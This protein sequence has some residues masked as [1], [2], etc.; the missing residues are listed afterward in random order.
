MTSTTNHF[1]G[2][3][4]RPRVAVDAAILQIRLPLSSETRSAPSEATVTPTGRPHCSTGVPFS[5]VLARKPVMKSSIGPGLPLTSVKNATRYPE[6]TVRFHDPCS[7]T[8]PP[9]RYLWGNCEPV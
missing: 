7:A 6:A 9:L 5:P 4:H 8:K 2:G 3:R 1:D